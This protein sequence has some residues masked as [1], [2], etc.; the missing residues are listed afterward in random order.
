MT[1]TS[2]PPSGP[3]REL[4]ILGTTA[5]VAFAAAP[6]VLAV[7]RHAREAAW[8]AMTVA[9]AVGTI[10]AGRSDPS[11]HVVLTACTLSVGIRNATCWSRTPRWLELA[12]LVPWVIAVIVARLTFG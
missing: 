7:Q 10:V 11:W 9:L 3:I 12:G 8:G 6:L 4:A 2:L 5:L 1:L